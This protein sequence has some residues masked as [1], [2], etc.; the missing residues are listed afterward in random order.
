VAELFFY[1]QSI[2]FIFKINSAMKRNSIVVTETDYYRLKQLVD[3]KDMKRKNDGAY[4]QRLYIEL[5]RAK[6]VDPEK[7]DPNV[8]TMNTEIDF[9]DLTTKKSR[10]IKLVYPDQA[11]ISK[12]WVSVL[13]PIGTALLGYCKGDV[14]EWEVPLGK[15]Q[16]MIREILYQPEANGHYEA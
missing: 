14:I 12:G 11:D 15:K 4:Y 16:F 5:E 10:Q 2:L 8:V 7:V 6:K 1:N 3:I 9:L 13:A